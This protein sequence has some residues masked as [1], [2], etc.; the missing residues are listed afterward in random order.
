MRYIENVNTENCDNWVDYM[1]TIMHQCLYIKWK[2][3]CRAA[4]SAH[5]F[6]LGSPSKKSLQKLLNH[7]LPQMIGVNLCCRIGL[8]LNCSNEMSLVT[9][10]ECKTGLLLLCKNCLIIQ[11]SLVTLQFRDYHDSPISLQW[12]SCSKVIWNQRRARLV[13]E[14]CQNRNIP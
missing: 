9:F 14:M 11:L 2:R 3:L 6:L 10:Y 8:S 12:I 4:S 13:A 5:L 1:R 7:A